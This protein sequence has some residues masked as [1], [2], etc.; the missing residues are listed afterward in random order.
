MIWK[1]ID[2]INQAHG[3]TCKDI[4]KL[5]RRIHHFVEESYEPSYS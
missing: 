5:E 3:Y 2:R 1:E 4:N